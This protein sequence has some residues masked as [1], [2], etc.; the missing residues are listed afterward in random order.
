MEQLVDHCEE[1]THRCQCC[2]ATLHLRDDLEERFADP[3][4]NGRKACLQLKSGD[5]YLT[6]RNRDGAEIF[7]SFTPGHVEFWLDQEF[8]FFLLIRN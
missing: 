3:A 1:A 8:T 5:A 2:D 7:K 6:T 4:T